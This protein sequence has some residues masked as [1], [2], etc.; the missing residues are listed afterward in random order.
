MNTRFVSFTDSNAFKLTD[1]LSD[2]IWEIVT[3]WDWFAKRTIGT[4]ITTAFDSIPAN[5]AEGFG[6]YHKKDK[7]KFY[8]NAR[9]SAY[10][11]LFW[12]EKAS[13]R[14]LITNT[15]YEELRKELMAVPKEI[16]W[17]IK[18]TEEKLKV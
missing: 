13:K 5:L 4:Q 9:G 2:R 10:E 18:V 16:N 11:S 6:R 15:Q 8:Y 14:K 1:S 17:L 12:A 7:Q 3:V